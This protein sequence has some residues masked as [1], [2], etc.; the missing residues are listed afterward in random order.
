M[1]IH[2]NDAIL[3]IKDESV[4]WADSRL[5]EENLNYHGTYVK[6]LNLKWRKLTE[7]MK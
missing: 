4:F 3:L 5:E 7:D 1:G 2:L 6:A